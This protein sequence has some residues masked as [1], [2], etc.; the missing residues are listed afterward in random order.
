MMPTCPSRSTTKSRAG[1]HQNLFYTMKGDLPQMF[2][3][4]SFPL[5]VEGCQKLI[6]QLAWNESFG[7]FSRAGFEKWIWPQI[8]ERARWIIYFDLNNIHEL[9]AAHGGYEPVDQMIRLG[10]SVLRWSDFVAGQVK[11]G[12]EF[13]VCMLE[14]ESDSP[15]AGQREK[16]D[17]QALMER[18]K[19][20]LGRAG[21]TAVFSIV[22]VESSDLMTV[23]KPA[24]EHVFAIKQ[25]RARTRRSL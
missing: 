11:S 18:L 6:R 21:L 3:T 25:N 17:P 10:L 20:S 2:E 9:N 14:P 19:D 4:I 1:R 5:T 22:P 8:Q 12:D 7:C 15:D 16:L 24:I 13:L 23:L